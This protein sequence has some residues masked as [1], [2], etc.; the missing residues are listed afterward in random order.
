MKELEDA[1][2]KIAVFVLST[3]RPNGTIFTVVIQ[4]LTNACTIIYP[5]CGPQ[6]YT[7]KPFKIFRLIGRAEFFLL[8]I[9]GDLTS[10]EILCLFSVP[11]LSI[12]D[13]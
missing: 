3:T 11:I 12:I 10:A 7:R 13:F 1:F 8:G 2:K 4:I 9:L 5:Y 6:D